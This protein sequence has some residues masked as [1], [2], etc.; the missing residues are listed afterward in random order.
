MG[1]GV[2]SWEARTCKK[3][4]QLE[5]SM[6]GGDLEAV[7]RTRAGKASRGL[8]L[9]IFSLYLKTVLSREVIY[10]YIEDHFAWPVENGLKED[11]RGCGWER[12]EDI[13]GD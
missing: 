1:R 8:T 6:R 9:R 4:V 5:G 11:G 2:R 7:S 13:I 12:T 10:I 3:L